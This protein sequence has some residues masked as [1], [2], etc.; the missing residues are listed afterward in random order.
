MKLIYK[1]QI[2]SKPFET[3]KSLSTHLQWHHKIP[4]KDYYDTYISNSTIH[5]CI[6]CGINDTTFLNIDDGYKKTCSVK[7]ADKINGRYDHIRQTFIEKGYINKLVEPFEVYKTDDLSK[8]DH[9]QKFLYKCEECGNYKT[10]LYNF[11]L[12]LTNRDAF[13]CNKCKNYHRQIEKYNKIPIVETPIFI[14]KNS[15]LNRYYCKQKV[16]FNCEICNEEEHASIGYMRQ[17]KRAATKFRCQKCSTIFTNRKLHGVDFICY[18]FT[19]PKFV[20]KQS[21]KF[22]NDLNNLLHFNYNIYY[23]KNEFGLKDKTTGLY[24]KYDFT[25]TKNKIIIEY[26]GDYWHPTCEND[27][28]WKNNRLDCNETW[29]YDNNKRKCAESYGFKVIY[30]W[31]HEVNECYSE[32]LSKC[33]NVLV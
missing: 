17:T 30:I 18:L 7:C 23:N 20:S 6:V 33:K 1:C 10:V 32:C 24:Y 25:D 27:T 28:N 12:D 16:R 3:R 8:F 9:R 31:E 4:N 13:L 21:I 29:M 5:K 19:N 26:N 22:F 15:D 2:C 14:D 11:N